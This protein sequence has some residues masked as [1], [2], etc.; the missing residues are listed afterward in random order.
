MFLIPVYTYLGVLVM[1]LTCRFLSSSTE[2]TCGLYYYTSSNIL[3]SN[4]KE[5]WWLSGK[6][7]LLKLTAYIFIMNLYTSI[8]AY[9]I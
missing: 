4:A 3:Y 2:L 1:P 8:L 9:L 7:I 6:S 5:L